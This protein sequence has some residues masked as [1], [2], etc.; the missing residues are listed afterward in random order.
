M[1]YP[2]RFAVNLGKVIWGHMAWYAW[3]WRALLLVGF[4][5]AARVTLQPWLEQFG[6][7]GVPSYSFV[8][9]ALIVLAIGCAAQA[10]AAET[11]QVELGPVEVGTGLN[12]A[13]VQLPLRSATAKPLPCRATLNIH[14]LDGSNEPPRR[15]SLLTRNQ[16]RARRRNPLYSAQFNLDDAPKNLDLF[17][18]DFGAKTIQ[19]EHEDGTDMLPLTSY[20]L[21]VSIIAAGRAVKKALTLIKTG[22]LIHLSDGR[23]GMDVMLPS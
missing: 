19:I 17:T 21:E 11:S 13:Q 1:D 6:L 10:A 7:G 4:V 16:V 20:R 2:Q 23:W 14:M 12:L 3:F 22:D 8:M 5:P 15:F 18:C 9:F